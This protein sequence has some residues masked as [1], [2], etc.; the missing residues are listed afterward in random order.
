MTL[1]EKIREVAKRLLKEGKVEAILGYEKGPLPFRNRIVLIRAPEEARRLCWPSFGVLNPATALQ[2]IK[3]IRVGVFVTGCVSRA[4]VV[5]LKERQLL[6]ENLHLI[7]VPCPGMLDP[8][9]VRAKAPRVKALEDNLSGEVLL[10]T[11]EEK[12]K[13]LRDDLLR[14][15]CLECRHPNPPIYDELLEASP[16]APAESPY[17]RVEEIEAQSISAR[18]EWFKKEILSRCLRCYA[19]RQA[20]PLC[21]C[22][23]CFVDDSRPQWVGKSRDPID[24]ALYHLVRAYHL[25]GRC[26]DCGS[27]EAACPMDIPLRLLTK[28]LEKEALSAFSFEAGLNPEAP[29][30]LNTFDENDPEDFMLTHELKAAGKI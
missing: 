21:Y 30:L 10:V 18:W 9:K 12:V 29:L 19:C 3:N 16:R 20:C 14:N 11:G 13:I 28:K 27:C 1:T 22:P 5:L 6:R 15:N 26:V 2:K 25:A 24:T 4:I 8:S 7:G 17:R 23:L